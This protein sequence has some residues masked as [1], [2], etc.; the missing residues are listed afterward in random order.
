M[1][2][3]DPDIRIKLAETPQDFAVA[4]DLIQEYADWLGVDLCF[5]NYEEELARLDAIYSPPTGRLYLAM[6]GEGAAGCIGLRALD[7]P[8]E[9]ELKRLYVRPACRGLGLGKALVQRAIDA[10]RQIGYRLLRL[11]TWPPRM[12]E[13]QAMY[14]RL[15][16]VETP[17]YYNNPVPGVVFMQLDLET[18]R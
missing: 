4:R 8:G 9:G 14:R 16:C 12:P 17:P 10:A 1:T 2:A 11:D 5:Q 6:K 7:A 13:A 3:P 15:G 18:A